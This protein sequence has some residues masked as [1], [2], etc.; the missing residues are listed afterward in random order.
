M[1]AN[2]YNRFSLE[3]EKL[4]NLH[5]FFLYN[6]FNFIYTDKKMIYSKEL[7][8]ENKFQTLNDFNIENNTIIHISLKETDVNKIK[9]TEKLLI[10][11]V[12]EEVKQAEQI[13]NSFIPFNPFLNFVNTISN[14]NFI[15][16]IQISVEENLKDILKKLKFQYP[17]LKK[18]IFEEIRFGGK[19]YNLSDFDEIIF[20]SIKT[21]NLN[22]YEYIYLDGK[23]IEDS[24]IE[25]H[26]YWINN[27]NTEYI[28]TI[29]KKETFYNAVLKL[30]NH[31]DLTVYNISLCYRF[32]NINEI[33]NIY[34]K[35]NYS[36]NGCNG[37]DGNVNN[38]I[39]N[40]MEVDILYN[41]T[42]KN[43]KTIESLNIDKD[44]K[45]YFET[46]KNILK[47]EEKLR[48]EEQQKYEKEYN[49]GD[50]KL[51]TINTSIGNKYILFLD[52]NTKISQVL[53]ILKEKYPSFRN[54]KISVVLYNVKSLDIEKTIE[55]N[56][57]KSSPIL[58]MID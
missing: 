38:A 40:Q 28:I 6:E 44:S 27:S 9:D 24:I 49:N 58:I 16:R 47:I 42:E 25:L 11:K 54:L 31:K 35:M 29:G 7:N 37:C 4:I 43:Y 57:I 30:L 33:R 48:N 39:N 10:D 26:F 23:I 56:E 14:D 3:L 2:A 46:K 52:K 12:K 55:E 22:I 51:I 50:K 17:I 21:L 1:K 13:R 20:R 53:N 5:E 45:I 32:F 8:E 36:I 41:E 18:Y 34:T 15:Y 19:K